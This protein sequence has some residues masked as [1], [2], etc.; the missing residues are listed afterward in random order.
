MRKHS[1]ILAAD[2]PT[3]AET[4]AVIGEVGTIVDGIKIG[5]ATLLQAGVDILRRIKDLIEDRPLLVDLKIA[6]IGFKGRYSWQGTNAKIIES[7]RDTGAT[8]VTVHGFPGPTSV[9]EAADRAKEAGIGVLLLPLMSH[10]GAALFFT[11]PLER[12]EVVYSTIKAGI[13]VNFPQELNCSD[14]TEGIL[15]L[16]EALNV[17]GYI[18]P[19]TRPVDLQRY[20]SLTLKPIWCPG[21]GRQ[22]RQGRNLEEQFKQWAEIV[23]PSSAAIVGSAIFGA[24]DREAAAKEIVEIRDKVMG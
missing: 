3:P 11:R 16:G 4:L 17:E 6:D 23:G 21:F 9:A 5:E 22:D 24:K 20:R 12:S 2:L 10:A 13:D 14:V 1:I 19:A 18:G 15:M 8:H 7:I